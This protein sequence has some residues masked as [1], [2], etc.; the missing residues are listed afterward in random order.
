MIYFLFHLHSHTKVMVSHCT[1]SKKDN[2]WLQESSFTA[3]DLKKLMQTKRNSSLIS[4][5]FSETENPPYS[6]HRRNLQLLLDIITLGER[7]KD[8]VLHTW[9]LLHSAKW[10]TE[11]MRVKQRD[12]PVI[13]KNLLHKEK[14]SSK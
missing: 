13:L 14:V 7:H 8:H 4:S 1:N 10:E 11:H 9:H 3:C 5:F 2:F 6:Y 12:F